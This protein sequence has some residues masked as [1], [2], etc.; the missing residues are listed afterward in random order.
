MVHY[1]DIPVSKRMDDRLSEDFSLEDNDL[2]DS[3]VL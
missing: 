1:R 2:V 3:V